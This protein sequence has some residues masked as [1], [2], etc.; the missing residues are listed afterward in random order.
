MSII[1]QRRK[2]LIMSA[3]LGFMIAALVLTGSAYAF[4]L[5]IA[6]WLDLAVKE[7]VV[8]PLLEAS[9]VTARPIEK[10]SIIDAD[11][12]TTIMVDA[13][14]KV[15]AHFDN[16]EEVVGKRSAIDLDKNMPIISPMFLDDLPVQDNL[17]LYEVSFVELP[18]HLSIGEVVDVRIA[19]PTGQE[20]VVLSKKEV[21]GFERRVQN[22][23]EG[24]INLALDEEEALRMSSALVDMYIAEGARVYMVKYVEPSHQVSAIVN[25]PVNESV[26]KLLF[27]NPNIVEATLNDAMLMERIELNTSLNALLGEDNQPVY[28]VD[29]TTPNMT[30][31]Q[32]LQDELSA[33]QNTVVEPVIT[34]PTT[35][36]TSSSDNASGIGF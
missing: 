24:L 6:R 4:R 17:R 21:R 2:N 35:D 11:D 25:Y 28:Q 33:E 16:I 34:L 22:I 32:D 9:I 23:H 30:L 14:T 27:D 31:N 29:M 20:Y 26:Y 36:S 3:L 15:T 1:R 8:Q 5:P 18:Y 12:L 13:T 19:F 10:G 7:E